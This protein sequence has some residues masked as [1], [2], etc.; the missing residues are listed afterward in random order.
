MTG[1]SA[2]EGVLSTGGVAVGSM[3]IPGKGALVVLAAVACAVGMA[4]P[5]LVPGIGVAG[6]TV[7]RGASVFSGTI[8]VD[9]AAGRCPFG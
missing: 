5:G 7:C 9:V 3:M 2:G 4:A 6:I 8:G 1:I